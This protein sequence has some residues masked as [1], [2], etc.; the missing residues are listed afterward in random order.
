VYSIYKKALEAFNAA[1]QKF[2][3]Y[4]NGSV[5][6]SPLNGYVASLSKVPGNA[7]RPG[8]LLISIVDLKNLLAEV[9]V[10][11]VNVDSIKPGQPVII[12]NDKGKYPGT[13]SFV[14]LEVNQ[15]TGSR[16][17]GIEIFQEKALKLLPGDFVE[18]E[19]IVKKHLSST[20]IPEEAVLNDGGQ[21]FAMVK[22][23]QVYKKR[24]IVTG[25]HNQDYLEVLDGLSE[26]E[27]VATTGAY[28][29]F[30]REIKKKLKIE[31]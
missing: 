19:I 10:F 22:E 3:F 2:D 21:E 9:E 23:E 26:G 27:E 7:I 20:A 8:E 13:I 18:A 29:L 12:A 24:A 1:R 25:L 17:V 6:T 31:D 5:I 4:A 30:N 11:S 28:E 15:K 16:K 14:S